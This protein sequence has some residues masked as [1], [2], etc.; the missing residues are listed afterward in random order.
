MGII[1]RAAA[2]AASAALA[3]GLAGCGGAEPEFQGKTLTVL[4]PSGVY[5]EAA[6]SVASEF[7]AATGADLRVV[8]LPRE[9]LLEAILTNAEGESAL[10]DAVAA[11]AR[12]DGALSPHLYGLGTYIA[13]AEEEGTL[14]LADFEPKVLDS[15]GSW[16]GSVYGIPFAAAPRLFAYRTDIYPDGPAARWD[17]Y[18]REAADQSRD[19]FYGLSLGGSGG[20]LGEL[21]ELLLRGMGGT[22][23]T[24][25]SPE[26][27]A[28]LKALRTL[29]DSGA[30]S[31]DWPEWDAETAADAFLAGNAAIC[32]SQPTW[33]LAL[34]ADDPAQSAIVGNWALCLP[35]S[36]D[37]TAELEAWSLGI[38]ANTQQPDLAWEW[39]RMFT[40][41]ANQ[42]RFYEEY[43]IL[44]P[45]SSFWER[46][47]TT[48]TPMEE[49]HAALV[50]TTPPLRVSAA[51]EAQALLDTE[52]RAFL[53][54]SREADE[55]ISRLDDGL[56]RILRNTHE[57]PD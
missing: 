26:G 29:R 13:K 3:L 42:V 52:L 16:Q 6:R 50:R 23:E 17:D 39:I 40:L 49:I 22:L 54:G 15:C 4:Y 19:G 27:R 24:A 8:D 28:A 33:G 45:R 25:D 41:P 55:T 31:P 32:Q 1:K 38:C 5:A 34:R 18:L 43:G 37:G 11:D 12:W 10:Y 36:A 44:P 47:G 57:L 48:G 51:A 46:D 56:S 21:Y 30:A 53:S 35:P 20:Q 9:Q 14:T 7:T 2:L